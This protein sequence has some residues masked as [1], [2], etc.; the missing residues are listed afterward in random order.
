MEMRYERNCPALT[1]DQCAALAGKRICVVGCGGLGGYVV[2]LLAR[3]GVGGITV[4]DPDAFSES[5]L[6]RQLFATQRTLAQSK[7][8]AAF[9]RI[10][11]VNPSI[12][13]HAIAQPFDAQ[14]AQTLLTGQ[15]AAVDALDNI[16]ARLLL[17]RCCLTLGIPFVHGAAEGW[18]GQ[19]CTVLPGDHTL[20]HLY[21]G[22]P[23][24]APGTGCLGVAAAATAAVQSSEVLKLLLGVPC[25]LTK[26]LLQLDL[27]HNTQNIVRLG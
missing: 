11:E 22:H 25:V 13:L 4:V 5:N 2:E 1:P 15:D 23:G 21:A 19:V 16:P 10:A 18:C 14:T 24:C 17:E 8:Q 3:A 26:Q 20:A 27:L 7:V 9:A 12:T 6:N